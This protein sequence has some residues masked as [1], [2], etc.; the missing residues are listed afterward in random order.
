MERIDLL[1][2]STSNLSSVRGRDAQR[3]TALKCICLQM[4]CVNRATVLSA[5]IPSFD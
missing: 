3:R 5:T 2:V 1:L 4:F